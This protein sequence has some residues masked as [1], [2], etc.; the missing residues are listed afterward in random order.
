[1]FENLSQS[2]ANAAAAVPFGT[3]LWIIWGTFIAIFVL[4]VTLTVC[5][6]AVRSASKRP[7]LCL[8]Y[9]YTALTFALFLT[10]NKIEDA[11]FS[12]CIFWITGYVGYGLLCAISKRLSRE[13]PAPVA[14]CA[15]P[16]AATAPIQTLPLPAPEPAAMPRQRERTPAGTFMPK[17]NVRLEHAIAVTNKLLEKNLGKTDRQEL[18]K[19]KNTLEV[20][21]VKG[22]LTPAEG[23]ILNENFNTLLKLMAK[24][25]I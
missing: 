14:V 21:K 22:S 10:V 16:A 25:N 5:L 23:E 20:M 11:A 12:A 1:M 15:A 4:S 17:N 19:L 13:Y 2:V 18:E 8:L 9:A 3:L 24:Y 6:P 7:F